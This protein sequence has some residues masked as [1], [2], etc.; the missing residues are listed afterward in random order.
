LDMF[1]LYSDCG[2]YFDPASRGVNAVQPIW[3]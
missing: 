1:V 3:C 2:R